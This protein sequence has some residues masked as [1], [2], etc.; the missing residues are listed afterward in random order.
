VHHAR[1]ALDHLVT[2]LVIL[3]GRKPHTRHQFPVVES[4]DDW[5]RL[6]NPPKNCKGRKQRGYLDF[7]PDTQIAVI[8]SAQPYV[9]TTGK[10]SLVT[11][12]RFSNADK[13]RLIHASVTW[14]TEA[15][16]ITMEIVF[17]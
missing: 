1:G 6:V 8:K 11:L 9:P 5:N 10:P 4:E 3:S 7:I 12:Q 17:P 2:Q 16:E 14:L 13:H 15:P